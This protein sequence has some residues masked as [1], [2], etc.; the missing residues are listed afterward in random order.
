MFLIIFIVKDGGN[1]WRHLLFNFSVGLLVIIH[2]LLEQIFKLV[3]VRP[4]TRS[5]HIMLSEIACLTH[6]RLS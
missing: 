6:L 3:E 5:N 1:L 2:S 4:K